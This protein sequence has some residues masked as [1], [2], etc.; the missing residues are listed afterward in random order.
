MYGR[1]QDKLY[2]GMVDATCFK[3]PNKGMEAVAEHIDWF[4]EWMHRSMQLPS[5]GE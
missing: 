3:T 2:Q 1:N 4:L 5:I